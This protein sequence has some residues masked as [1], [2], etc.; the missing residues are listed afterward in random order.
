MSKLQPLNGYV[1]L[2]P[3]E[4]DE[5]LYGS[6]VIPDTG[7][8]KPEMGEVVATSPTYNYNSDTF[9]SS[10]IVVGDKVLIP[11]LGSLRVTI[12]SDE[13]FICKEQDVYSKIVPENPIAEIFKETEAELK[14]GDIT[15]DHYFVA[16][17]KEQ[18]EL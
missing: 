17:I 12:D 6:I 2:K 8:E 5:T 16:D 7:K 13:Y 11:K 3:I 9:V 4:E 1:I 14:K 18:N 15:G 10:N